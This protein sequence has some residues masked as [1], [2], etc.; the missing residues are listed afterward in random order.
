MSYAIMRIEKRKGLDSVRRAALHNLREVLTPNAD[1]ERGIRILVGPEDAAQIVSQVN[2]S[3]KPLMKRKDAIRALEVLCAMSPDFEQKGISKEQFEETAMKWAKQT[4]GEKNIISAVVHE[5]ETTP[6]IQL[7]LV[8]ITPQGK[9]AASFWVDG[10]KKLSM[11]QDS[12]A[13]AMA[14]LGLERGIKGS[15]A[16]HEKIKRYYGELEPNMRKAQA[17]IIEAEKLEK[18]LSEKTRLNALRAAQVA[19]DHIALTQ[20]QNTLKEAKN[21]FAKDEEGF[22]AEVD[23]KLHRLKAVFSEIER[24]KQAFQSI[25]KKLPATLVAEVQDFLGMGSPAE[26]VRKSEAKK[27]LGPRH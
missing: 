23:S 20:S 9:L 16:K 25:L 17:A 22:K 21:R 26:E 15:K 11:M 5:D 19:K 10:P 14:P 6:H 8:P 12:Y 27:R 1:P 24:Q 3:T 7:L 4:F 2:E 18:E 13:E